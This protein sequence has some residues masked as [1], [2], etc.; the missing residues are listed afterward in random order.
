MPP[1]LEVIA[2][3][4]LAF[5]PRAGDLEAFRALAGNDRDRLAAYVDLQLNPQ[6][7]DDTACAA[8]LDSL[9]FATLGK[10]L[11]QLWADH[12]VN[13]PQDRGYEWRNLPLHET[14]DASFIKAVYSRRQLFEVLVDFWHNH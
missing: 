14:V 2:L 5:G 9:D 7:I 8:R 6:L 4:R 13:P 11:A 1:P 10:P 3:N 12:A